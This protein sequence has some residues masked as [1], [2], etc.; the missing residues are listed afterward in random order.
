MGLCRKSFD[1]KLHGAYFCFK[2]FG[3]LTFNRESVLK[4]TEKYGCSILALPLNW[5]GGQAVGRPWGYLA[6]PVVHNASYRTADKIR[7]HH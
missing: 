4:S 6:E 1:I 7:L 5:S 2:G 3:L